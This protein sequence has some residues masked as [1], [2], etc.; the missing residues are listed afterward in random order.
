MARPTELSFPRVA[1]AAD[2]MRAA[3]VEPTVK[4]LLVQLGGSPNTILPFFQLWKAHSGPAP[5]ARI[6]AVVTPEMG[7]SLEAWA[8]N[9]LALAQKGH[10]AVITAEQ[11]ARVA[12]EEAADER[13]AQ[14]E[15]TVGS[16]KEL[17]QAFRQ[18]DEQL[19]TAQNELGRLSGV[20]VANERQINEMKG[21]VEAARREAVAAQHRAELAEQRVLLIEEMGSSTQ[22]RKGN[23]GA[24][25]GTNVKATPPAP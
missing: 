2:A 8:N 20:V 11:A 7:A 4:T 23:T 13:G 14:L 1:A 24:G 22:R 21:A 12:A 9:L 17:E 19:I 3:G 6:T 10:D 16:M 25:R 18:R 15:S 5:L